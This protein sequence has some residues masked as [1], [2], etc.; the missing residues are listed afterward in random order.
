MS[1]NTISFWI[2]FI[3]LVLIYSYLPTR[4]LRNILLL[5][6][7]YGIYASWD[8]R[9]LPIIM[10]STVVDYFVGMAIA[11]SRGSLSR[12]M[13]LGLSLSVNLGLL[14]SF[15]YLLTLFGSSEGSGPFFALLQD[16]G[17][18]LGISFYTFQTLSYTIDVYRGKIKAC[19]NPIDFALY[20]SF[21]PQLTAGP[22]EK[23][24]RFLPQIQRNR[25]ANTKDRKE[26]FV[27]IMLGLVKKIYVADSLIIAVD[28][29]FYRGIEPQS[30]LTV[31]SSIL[32]TFCVYADFS[33]YS[34]MARGMAKFFG[35]NL[36]QNYKP[37]WHS[38]SPE[39]FW[40]RWHISFMEWVRDYLVLPFHYPGR[41]WWITNCHLILAMVLV[42]LWHGASWNWFLFGL[43]HGLALVLSRNWHILYRKYNFSLPSFFTTSFGLIFMFTLY[44]TSGLLHASSDFNQVLSLLKNLTALTGFHYEAI[45]YL[46]YIFQFLAPLLIYEIVLLLKKDEFFCF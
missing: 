45:D 20:V 15:K 19:A 12:K 18:P 6:A 14:F 1:F 5:G 44:F 40:R 22:I 23:A 17:L 42:G 21:F 11:R 13:A 38:T 29:M 24:R 4:M 43:I 39:K 26:G 27:L 33:G 32:M 25:S 46:L 30:T 16:I 10:L 36:V 37:F 8:W 41:P 31:L 9:F 28:Y 34:D 3:P 35:I 2:V 7:S